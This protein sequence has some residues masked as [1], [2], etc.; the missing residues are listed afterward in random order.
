VQTTN[1]NLPEITRNDDDAPGAGGRGA[2]TLRHAGFD[3]VTA[4]YGIT[5][6]WTVSDASQGNR[7]QY[8]HLEAVAVERPRHDLEEQHLSRRRE[9]ALGRPERNGRARAG[10]ETLPGQYR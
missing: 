10:A 4:A 1:F 6:D 9:E 8:F 2:L 7:L 5:W 3:L